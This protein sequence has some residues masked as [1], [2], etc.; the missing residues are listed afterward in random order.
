M[1]ASLCVW[2]VSSHVGFGLLSRAAC[3]VLR[4]ILCHVLCFNL[5]YGADGFSL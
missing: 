2:P 4:H 5:G 1:S 3:P